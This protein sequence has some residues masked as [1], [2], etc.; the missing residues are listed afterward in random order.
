MTRI[1]AFLRHAGVFLTAC[2]AFACS[3]P[4]VFERPAD[5]VSSAVS[6]AVSNITRNVTPGRHLGF[7]TYS[8]PGDAAMLAWRDE[9][10]RYEWVG[11]YLEAPCHRE[12]SWTGKRERLEKMGWGT[13]VI[14]VGQQTWGR[15]PGQRIVRTKYVTRYVRKTVRRNG[16]R[17]VR[18]IPIRKAVR[19][20]VQPRAR[21]GSSCGTQ[22]VSAARGRIDADDAIRKTI[23]EGF[24]PGT[25]IFL[26]IERMEVVPRRMREY[27]HAW[28]ERVVE[29]GRF[30]AGYY[31][32]KKNAAQIHR[33]VKPVFTAKGIMADPPFW[34]AGG[35]G[36]SEDSAPHEVGHAFANVWQGILDIEQTHKGFVLPIDVNVSRF[37][38]PSSHL[39]GD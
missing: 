25:V 23:R 30:R 15:V 7:D 24:A 37:P 18:K 8:Y 35:S 17:V 36:F 10:V 4:D 27:Y 3:A 6:N 22:L 1:P 28:T 13:A 29:D 39:R 38:S 20:V 2:A 16:K 26:D 31:A 9:S 32:H 19:I 14:Y 11:Y 21:P 34:I 5:E 33:D 12:A